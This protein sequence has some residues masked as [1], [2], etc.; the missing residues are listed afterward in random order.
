MQ[1]TS[2]ALTE[3][4]EKQPKPQ[5]LLRKSLTG[6][7]SLPLQTFLCSIFHCNKESVDST[8]LKVGFCGYTSG[9]YHLSRRALLT[10]DTELR[11]MAAPPII[12]LRVGPPK[13][14]K[15]PAATGIPTT[16]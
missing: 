3:R 8:E 13:I 16:L 12:G 9:L 11:A 2:S 14:A 1:A 5:S 10:T 7:G 6:D 15:T 4:L